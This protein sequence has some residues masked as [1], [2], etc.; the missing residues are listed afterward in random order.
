MP[1]MLG[2]AI[3]ALLG[4]GVWSLR[5]LESAQRALQAA[6]T[7]AAAARG[8]AKAW[9]QG[10]GAALGQT[11]AELDAVLERVRALIEGEP[12]AARYEAELAGILEGRDRT[13]TEL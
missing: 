13:E 3:L 9:R 10:L 7:D 12:V 1:W 6:R 2:A 8:E 4:G 11:D 5:R